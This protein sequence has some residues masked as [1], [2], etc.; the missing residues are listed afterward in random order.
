M[1]SASEWT[2]M[3][4]LAGDNDLSPASSVDLKE[5]RAVGSTPDVNILAQVDAPGAAGATRYYIRR[6]GVEEQTDPLGVTDSGHPQTLVD[7]I[8]W[9]ADKYPARRYAL[10]LWNH[11]GGWEP[12]E[13][14]RLASEVGA[15][16]YKT[17]EGNERSGSPLRRALFRPTLEKILSLPSWAERAICSDDGSGHSLDTIELSRALAL[18]VEKIKQP[19]DLLG[20]DACLMN[21]FEVAYQV[22]PYA[23]YMVASE[24]DEPNNGWPYAEVFRE[25]VNNASIPTDRLASHIVETYV[26][27]YAEDDF[28][29]HMPVTQAAC[30]LSRADAV[31]VALDRLAGELVA[32]MPSAAP[33]LWTAQRGSTSFARKTLWDISHLC[34]ELSKLFAADDSLRRSAEDVRAALE[35][36]NGK[37]IVAEAH[38]GKRLQHCRGSSIYLIPP[39]WSISPYYQ[40]LDFSKDCRWL[41]LLKAYHAA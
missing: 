7:F 17:G 14:D 12:S 15:L 2:F 24:E 28:K 37:F 3:I 26:R 27:S 31:A 30:D 34:Q 36:G 9:A 5:M 19:F 8:E 29:M 25:V 11:G 20:M 23:R 4:Y 13:M 22:R 38:R 40:D 1:I 6:D 35:P 41:A 10:I 33:H 39:R 32:R 16:N 21:N 18:A